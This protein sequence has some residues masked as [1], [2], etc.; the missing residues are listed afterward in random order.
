MLVIWGLADRTLGPEQLERW[1]QAV[2]HAEVAA[3]AGVGHW[4]HEE[5]PEAVIEALRAFVDA[6]ASMRS[7]QA[8]RRT[9]PDAV[10]APEPS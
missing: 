5:V 4:P 1:K 8:A 9:T 10:G 3:L 6:P 7:V 2:P